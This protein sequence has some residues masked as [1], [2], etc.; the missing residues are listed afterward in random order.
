VKIKFLFLAI[1][2]LVGAKGAQA[3]PLFFSNV[4]ALQNNGTTQV[5]LFSNPG[6][7]LVGPQISFLV[8]ITGML[9]PGTT[10]TL[11]VSYSEA[12]GPPVV[13]SFQIPLFGSV[14]P[15]FTLIFSVAMGSFAATPATLTLDLLNSNP[16]F[17]F[18][19]GASAGLAV[20]SYTYSFNVSQPVPEPATLALLGAGLTGLFA[21]VRRRQNSKTH[22]QRRQC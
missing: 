14:Q 13:Q 9:P 12:G 16:D 4:S 18:P 15:P 8:D 5:D 17:I 11:L 19:S 1:L 10:D 3:D 2:I 22:A 6:A 7:T 20:N 21:R